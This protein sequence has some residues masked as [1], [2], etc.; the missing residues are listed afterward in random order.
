MHMNDEPT[1]VCASQR[2]SSYYSNEQMYAINS[3][4]KCEHRNVNLHKAK[5]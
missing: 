1:N 4:N 2:R 3:A 5:K